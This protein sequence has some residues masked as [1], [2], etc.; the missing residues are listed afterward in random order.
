[1]RMQFW[2]LPWHS[3]GTIALL[4]SSIALE[5]SVASSTPFI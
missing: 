1:M 2:V 4:A 3:E 5:I